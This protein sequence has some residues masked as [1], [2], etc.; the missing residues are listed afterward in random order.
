MGGLRDDI[1][2][3]IQAAALGAVLVLALSLRLGPVL[4]APETRRGG[5][6]PYGDPSLYHALA[7]SLA[8]G[9]GFV[10]TIKTAAGTEE[11]PVIFRA[12]GY[13]LFLASLYAA[14]GAGRGTSAQ[15]WIGTLTAVR[16]IQEGM[17]ASLCLAAF[18]IASAA[19]SGA[20]PIARAA[21]AILA[22]L[23]Q[24][25][26]PY[27]ARW[28]STILTEPLTGFL[29]GWCLAAL[30]WASYRRAILGFAMA[31]LLAGALVLTRPEYLPWVPAAGILCLVPRPRAS[32]APRPLAGRT[33]ASRARLASGPL[34][35]I[36]C[37]AAA[38]AP[39]TLRNSLTF[40]KFIPVASGSLGEMLHRGTFEGSFPWNGWAWCP[41]SILSGP[42]EEAEMRALYGSYIQ[43]QS[44]GG[45]EVF[46]VDRA[47]MAKALARIAAKPADCVR[48]WLSNIPRLWYQDY[49]QIFADPEPSGI[50]ILAGLA[51]AAAGL[52]LGGFRDP[53]ILAAASVPAFL[54]L[55]Y[56]P[57]HI[58]PRYS[59]PA[60]P[61]LAAL[62]AYALARAFLALRWAM[63]KALPE[64]AGRSPSQR[65]IKGAQA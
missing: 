8:E 15:G 64:A 38:L 52:A 7:L 60:T 26:N 33:L 37:A 24:A 1:L 28:A 62:A 54:S 49:V 14:L 2:R 6:G 22:A 44:T 50:W 61:L 41:P 17:D 35:F 53:A 48:A 11:R 45:A 56:L 63:R 5:L 29:L 58:E 23:L 59:T 43:A 10:K 51:L 55:L 4:A 18:L 31:G 20:A 39:W 21:G 16:L 57:L 30:A 9:R 27:T 47:F 13:P 46:A 34:A 25:L 12:P 40:G 42:K 36:L 32:R 65:K 3:A 19:L